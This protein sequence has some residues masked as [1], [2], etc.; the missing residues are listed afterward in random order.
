MTI[1]QRIADD[2][3][4][5]IKGKDQTR[6]DCL[7]MLKTSAK[8]KQVEIGHELNDSEMQAVI[9]SLVRKGKEAAEEFRKGRREDLA[10][11]E[12]REIAVLMA[13]LPAQLT[14]QEIEQEIRRIVSELAPAGPKDLGKVMKAAMARMGG[15]AQGKDISDIAKKLLG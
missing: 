4:A 15:K 1:H 13:Y 2:L 7:R 3:K 14:P 10:L 5:A 8:L 9:S 11:K 12:E 6:A